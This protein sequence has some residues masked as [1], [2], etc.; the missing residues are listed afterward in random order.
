[1]SLDDAADF[2]DRVENAGGRFTMN[3][4]DVR[5]GFVRCERTIQSFGVGSI[6][7]SLA[8]G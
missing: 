5:D 3:D 1:M 2:D 8:I 7:R 4:G 6:R